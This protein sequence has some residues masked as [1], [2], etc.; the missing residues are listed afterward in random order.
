ML[1]QHN[2]ARVLYHYPLD[3]ASRQARISLSE[4]KLKFT[5][6]VVDPWGANDGLLELCAEGTPPAL[7]DVN[8][9]GPIMIVGARAICEYI[10]ETAPKARL[11]PD[12]PIERAKIR[13]LC[14]WFDIKF[15]QDVHA[16]TTHECLEKV[17]LSLGPPD[18]IILSAGRDAM[19]RHF[20]YISELLVRRDYLSGRNFSLA[21]IAGIAHLSC[22]DYIN[23][24]KWRDWPEIRDWYQK[25]KSRPS[26]QPLLKDQLQYINPPHHYKDLDF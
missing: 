9:S 1:I 3:P 10:I 23:E 12:D 17:I 25:L 13:R 6:E 5:S 7:R 22:L 2:F 26:V 4:A 19:N 8:A 18:Q 21:D 16:Y 20:D 14:D 24:I 11:M 15:T